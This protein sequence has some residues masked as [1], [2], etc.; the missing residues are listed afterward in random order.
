MKWAITGLVLLGVVAAL[1]AAVLVSTFQA[2]GRGAAVQPPA[3]EVEV[4]VAAKPIAAMTLLDS[5]CLTT[6][7][8]SREAAAEYFRSPAQVIGKVTS[9]P[10]M[11]GQ[12]ISKN[13]LVVDGSGPHLAAALPAG[14]RALSVSLADCSGMSGILYPGSIVDVLATFK[15]P[16]LNS[17]EEAIS[18]TLLQ[19]IE[20]LAV[21]NQTVLSP[22]SNAAKKSLVDTGRRMITLLVDAK[23]AEVL[24]LAT[25]HGNLSLALRNPRDTATTGHDGTLLSD[26]AKHD[27]AGM[28]GPWVSA[29]ASEN[30]PARSESDPAALA[31]RIGLPAPAS[32]PARP[33]WDAVVIRGTVVEKVSFELP[34]AQ[35]GRN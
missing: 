24:Q 12:G 2:S 4:A 14:R 9:V 8:M 10:L 30:P 31:P 29:T 23:Q 20:V 21:E 1:S 27:I 32:Q 35:I 6:Q 34:E 5:S 22:E 18:T 28:I 25:E 17:R 3:R 11:Q 26:L 33:M 15:I 13:C 7:M 19:G 16:S